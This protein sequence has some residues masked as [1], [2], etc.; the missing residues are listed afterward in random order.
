M[1]SVTYFFLVTLLCCDIK[2]K[3][4]LITQLLSY[5]K[6][7]QLIAVTD[8]RPHSKENPICVFPENKLHGL[9]PNLHI[10]VSV[11]NVYIHRIGHIYFCSRISGP[12]VGIYKSLTDT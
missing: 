2:R 9:S 8:D 1:C 5:N 11:S 12:I 3:V 10:H 7:K 6:E 4:T